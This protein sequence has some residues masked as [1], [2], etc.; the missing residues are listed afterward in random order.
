MLSVLNKVSSTHNSC[1]DA[2]WVEE[3]AT[4]IVGGVFDGCST[5]T[6]SHWASQ[7]F[8]YAYKKV[9]K[10]MLEK[11]EN[12]VKILH[13]W[14]LYLCLNKLI[15]FQRLLGLQDHN[16]LSTVVLFCYDKE[17]KKLQVRAFGDFSVMVNGVMHRNDQDNK[18]KYVGYLLNMNDSNM[19]FTREDILESAIMRVYKDVDAFALCTDGIDQIMAPHFPVSPYLSTREHALSLLL[20]LPRSKTHLTLKWNLLKKAKFTLNDDLSII[21]YATSESQ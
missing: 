12:P 17:A 9:Y 21:S 20:D 4:H 5:G 2:V 13:D 3:S 19:P 6:N 16:F 15:S 10:D 7:S 1:E 14:S 8:V 11:Q 18:P